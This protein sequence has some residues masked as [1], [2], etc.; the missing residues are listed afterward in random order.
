ME[1]WTV[2]H[3]TPRDNIRAKKKR[4]KEQNSEKASGWERQDSLCGSSSID[5]LLN[6]FDFSGKCHNNFVKLS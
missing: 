4:R 3:A 6:S 2:A 1:N 5:E